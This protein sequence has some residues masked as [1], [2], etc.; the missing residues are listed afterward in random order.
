MKKQPQRQTTLHMH[1]QHPVNQSNLSMQRILYVC[2][3][4]QAFT[5]FNLCTMWWITKQS[6][7]I[8][9]KSIK[10]QSKLILE[11]GESMERKRLNRS[12]NLRAKARAIYV[13]LGIPFPS[14]DTSMPVLAN[15]TTCSSRKEIDYR[16]ILQKFQLFGSPYFIFHKYELGID[17]RVVTP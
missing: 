6:R 14:I 8:S 11:K 5:L 17:H 4:M 10:N 3:S 2:T 12:S 13:R 9:V 7:D 16:Q 15:R 1:S